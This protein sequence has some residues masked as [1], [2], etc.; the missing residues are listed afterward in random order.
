MLAVPRITFALA[1][2]A[3]FPA[4]FAAVHPRFRTPHFSIMAFAVLTWL[5]SVFGGFLG[6]VTLS[7]VARLF[8]YGVV[9]AALP[10]LRRK[11][12][13][14]AGFRLPGGS[15]LGWLGVIICLVLVTQVSRDG[16]LVL[17]AT[18]VLAFL[19][20]LWVRRRAPRTAP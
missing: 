19:N 1:E 10:V 5:L 18:I 7:A 17:A 8:Y 4:I 3:D 13:R 14:A 20:W 9:C 15:I 6:N 16:L 11:Q 2:Q 12:P